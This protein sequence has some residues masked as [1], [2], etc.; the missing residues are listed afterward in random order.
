M[1]RLTSFVLEEALRQLRAWRD[2]GLELDLAVNVS[3]W[4]LADPEFPDQVGALLAELGIEPS[5]LELEV[6]ESVLL[7]ESVRSGGRLE[8]LSGEGI[9]VAIDD[10]GVGYSSLGQLKNLPAQVLK[11]DRSFIAGMV[12]DPSDAAIVRSTIELAHNLGL[13]VV[14]EGVET[15]LHLARLQE[16]RCDIGQGFFLGRPLPPGANPAAVHLAGSSLVPQPD[17]ANVVP[18]RAASA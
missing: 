13:E 3:F 18:L 7:S 15:E 9:R 10:F 4:D 8:R 1:R 2:A 14:A 12:S 17:G 6:T 11:I 5:S 16:A